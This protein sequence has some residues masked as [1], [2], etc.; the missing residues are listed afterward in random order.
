MA[1][2]SL[3][4]EWLLQNYPQHGYFEVSPQDLTGALGGATNALE[5]VMN[6]HGAVVTIECLDG[7][8]TEDDLPK[9]RYRV[10]EK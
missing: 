9:L 10:C 3:T 1:A 8:T 4:A 2:C 7:W 6:A 5:G